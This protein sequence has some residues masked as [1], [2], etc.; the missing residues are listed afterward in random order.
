MKVI[1]RLNSIQY[2]KVLKSRFNHEAIFHEVKLIIPMN[3]TLK[4]NL[5]GRQKDFRYIPK[6]MY[7]A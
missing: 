6:L 2:F 4:L 5:F 7:S 1:L 3:N